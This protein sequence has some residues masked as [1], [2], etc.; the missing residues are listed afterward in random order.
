MLVWKRF[1]VY[2]PV[3]NPEPLDARR[4]NGQFIRHDQ[5]ERVPNL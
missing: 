5:Q 4:N 3:W 2:D 1:R